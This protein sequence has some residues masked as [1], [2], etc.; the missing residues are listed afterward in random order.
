MLSLAIPE[1]LERC[2]SVTGAPSLE[3]D[4]FSNQP[5]RCRSD[6]AVGGPVGRLRHQPDTV[7]TRGSCT[8]HDNP[9]PQ[10]VAV[11]ALGREHLVLNGEV[12]AQRADDPADLGLVLVVVA[13]DD[14]ANRAVEQQ[15]EAKR[16]VEVEDKVAV[17]RLLTVGPTTICW[18]AYLLG[19]PCFEPEG[20]F[21]GG[22]FSMQRTVALA[23]V[24]LA[25]TQ[26]G[27]PHG[28]S[29]ADLQEALRLRAQAVAKKDAAVWDRLTTADFTTVLEDGRLQTKAERL[30]QLKGENPRLSR[31]RRWLNVSQR[32]ETPSS[33]A[34][35]GRTGRG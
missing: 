27:V 26:R 31:H 4:P 10:R 33:N 17:A 24:A 7:H 16:I 8:D 5:G 30:T 32:T 2:N 35:R 1:V 34:R 21:G 13:D 20:Q 22:R 25:L 9:D 18:S 11:A 15:L 28:K 12:I 29:P 19:R 23:A 3:M 6:V 14:I